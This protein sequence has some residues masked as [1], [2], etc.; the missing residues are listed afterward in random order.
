MLLKKTLVCFTGWTDK[1]KCSQSVFNQICLTQTMTENETMQRWWWLEAKCSQSVFN[2]ICL[3]LGLWRKMKQYKDDGGWKQS[4]RRVYSIKSVSLRLWRKMKRYKDDGGWKQ[5]VRRV[6]SIK[7]VSLRLCRKMK[8]C[9]DDGG[10]KQRIGSHTLFSCHSWKLISMQVHKKIEI[11]TVINPHHSPHHSLPHH[12]LP[13]HSLHL[14]L[15]FHSN[16]PEHVSLHEFADNP[17]TLPVQSHH[18]SHLHPFL[19]RP[20]GP[21]HQDQNHHDFHYHDEAHHQFQTKTPLQHREYVWN[22]EWHTMLL[23]SGLGYQDCTLVLREEFEIA[24]SRHQICA[25]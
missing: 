19:L 13:H 11:F 9:K 12:S 6:Y 22:C 1:A 15:S 17:P 24:V 23:G 18:A 2:Q 4:V 3:A 7:S 21:L 10:W 5:S 8:R 16:L 20:W 25:Q 14:H